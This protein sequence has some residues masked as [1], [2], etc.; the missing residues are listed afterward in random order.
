[1]GSKNLKFRAIE[2]A[3]KEH[4]CQF[5]VLIRL[6]PIFPANLLNYLLGIMPIKA[7]DNIK[8]MPGML[9]VTFSYC[10]LGAMVEKLSEIQSSGTWD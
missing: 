5:V 7:F 9:P 8:A 3:V 6:T 10:Y 4:G 1:M 2:K